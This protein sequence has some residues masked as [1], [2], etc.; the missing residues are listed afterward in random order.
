MAGKEDVTEVKLQFLE[1]MLLKKGTMKFLLSLRHGEKTSSELRSLGVKPPDKLSYI[2]HL[3][4]KE[5]DYN[6]IMKYSLT[7]RGKRLAD[8]M[9]ELLKVT[10]EILPSE[11]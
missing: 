5:R 2:L 3:V 11:D 6:G 1:R 8:S 4:H 7:S 9:A 10:D